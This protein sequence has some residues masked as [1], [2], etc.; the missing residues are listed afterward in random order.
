MQ[1]ILVQIALI[2]IL[3]SLN[4]FFALAELAILSAKK[5][6][7]QGLADQGDERAITYLALVEESTS[8][9]SNVQIGITLVGVA[10]GTIGGA[11]I[12]ASLATAIKELPL[13]GDY[14]DSIGIAVVILSITLLSLVIGELV[15]K[16]IALSKPEHFALLMAPGIKWL[17]K[18]FSPISNLLSRTTDSIVG[19]IGIDITNQSE[20]SLEE[21]RLMIDAGA[22]SG[23]LEP[24]EEMMLEQ[25][26]R[27][28]N[29][30]I[31]IISTS[32]S[33][34]GWLD[35]N[36]SQEEI[37]EFL[38]HTTFEKIPVAD[39]DLDNILGLVYV[40]KLL[41]KYLQTGKFNLCESLNPAV[42][43]PENM[44]LLQTLKQM[45]KS[46]SNLVF[47]LNEYGGVDGLVS[48]KDIL[49]AIAG[50]LPE[51]DEKY[52]PQ[53]VQRSDGSWLLDGML[54]IE[55]FSELIKVDLE[56]I[57][58]NHIKT[59]AGF[60]IT[61]L[62]KIPQTGDRFHAYGYDIEV[63]DMDNNRVDKVLVRKEIN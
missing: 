30:G 2:L 1:I 55:V 38:I 15:P 37:K 9:L 48:T 25:V 18:I 50:D 42:M 57:K 6:R 47:V 10:S 23:I 29:V 49:E 43:V 26:L 40:Q 36:A 5:L 52:D 54:L 4:G 62:K 32:R 20:V 19:W 56:K 34:I 46:Y 39:G 45:R 17:S 51:P 59:L 11:T 33:E 53:I 12:A 44:T 16:R 60:V 35:S 41:S 58:D 63:V 8:F 14:A 3:I 31:K 27:F 22:S 7:L 21:L 13:I 28:N 24:L 61:K